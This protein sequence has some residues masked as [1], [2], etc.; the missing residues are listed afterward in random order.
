MSTSRALPYSSGSSPGCTPGIS[1]RPLVNMAEEHH[2]N[3]TFF[4]DVRVPVSNRVGEENRGWYV[5]MTLLDFERSNITGAV[6]ARRN[7]FW[8]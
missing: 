1:V 4:E 8:W 6:S 5:S 2:F 7:W 3:E